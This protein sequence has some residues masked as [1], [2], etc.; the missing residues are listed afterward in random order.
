M[1]LFYEYGRVMVLFLLGRASGMFGEVNFAIPFS[2]AEPVRAAAVPWQCLR[3]DL[4]YVLPV[5][6]R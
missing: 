5:H 2:V 6:V 1:S 3:S 4:F